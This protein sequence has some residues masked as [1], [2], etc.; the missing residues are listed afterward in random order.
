MKLQNNG[1]RNAA[2]KKKLVL[3][4]LQKHLHAGVAQLNF[5]AI[6]S[7]ISMSKTIIPRSQNQLLWH[8]LLHRLL[9]LLVHLLVHLLMHLYQ[10]L[11]L[12]KRQKR[13]YFKRLSYTAFYSSGCTSYT[14]NFSYLQG[15]ICSSYISADSAAATSIT[16]AIDQSYGQK[17][18]HITTAYACC[19]EEAIH[20]DRRPLYHVSWETQE[21][22]L[23]YHTKYPIL[24]SSLLSPNTH[25]RLFQT[26]WKCHQIVENCSFQSIFIFK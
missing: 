21:K 25:H 13:P 10:R 20:D 5:L 6:R 23:G 16:L 11:Y 15:Y 8:Q 18:S 1:I 19:S 24:S 22:E 3:K 4:R 17:T 9:H 14:K 2:W 7:Y 12:L 26:S